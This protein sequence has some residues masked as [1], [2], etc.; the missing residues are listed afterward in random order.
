MSAGIAH[1]GRR[2]WCSTSRRQRTGVAMLTTMALGVMVVSF[3]LGSTFNVNTTSDGAD[4]N[5]GDGICEA[6]L[7]G[8]EN[9]CTLRAAIMES[10]AHPGHDTIE[11]PAGVY[12]LE[13]PT[14][15]EDLPDTGDFDI[16]T[17]LTIRGTDGTTR[18]QVII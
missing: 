3:V 14:L 8:E 9:Q 2:L 11:V 5:P 1:A 18:D 4:T 12:E 6:G 7:T 16:T 17:S 13:I 10:N 15:N